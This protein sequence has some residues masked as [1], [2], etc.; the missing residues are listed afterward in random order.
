MVAGQQQSQRRGEGQ[1]AV[2]AVGG[3]PFVTAVRGH[4][5]GQVLRVRQGVQAQAVV[6]D[7]HFPCR[8]LDV[9]QTVRVAQRQGEVPAYDAR[10]LVRACKLVIGEAAQFDMP[11]IVQDTRE[12]LHRLDELHRRLLVLYF[13]RYDMP[14]AQRIP[15][16][17]LPH[18]L[19]RSL[20]QEQVAL[21]VQE[22]ALVEVHLVAA[23]EEA[24]A[25][26]A[27][28]GAVPFLHVP[29]LLVQ[30]RM[31]GQYLDCLAP[32]GVDA[33]VF[34]RRDGIDLRKLHLEG[35]GDVRVF[36]DDAPVF[37][38]KQGEAAFQRGGFHDVSHTFL[39]FFFFRLN[40]LDTRLRWSTWRG[41]PCRAQ[42]HQPVFA[43]L[44]VQPER[45]PHERRGGYRAE[46]DAEP[47]ARACH[48]EDD[49]EDE[50]GEQPAREQEQVLRLQ[51]LELHR[52]ADALVDGVLSHCPYTLLYMY[53]I[54]VC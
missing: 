37:H 4:R 31:V 45:E 51:A 1:A 39:P 24:H 28:V 43:V 44:R 34:L 38:R 36:R 2:R 49:E 53:R 9:L 14:P 26:L 22:R 12:L 16:A 54:P 33:L 10:L 47:L 30:H 23:G 18:A 15:V 40:R 46:A 20:R 52:T 35:G 27:E 6:A 29:V 25:L 48:V 11:R 8:H 19:L 41:H 50:G 42:L 5:C 7:A 32:R 17:L 13:F 3:Q 21:V